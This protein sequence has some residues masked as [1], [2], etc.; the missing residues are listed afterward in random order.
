[1]KL[2]VGMDVSLA[3]IEIR[4]NGEHGE[5]VEEPEAASE[6]EVLARWPGLCRNGLTLPPEIVPSEC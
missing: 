1:M 5:I 2:F 3:K 6:P 4:A